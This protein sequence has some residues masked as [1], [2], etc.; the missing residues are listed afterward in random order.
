MSC[1]ENVLHIFYIA[2]MIIMMSVMMWYKS[3][4]V[5]KKAMH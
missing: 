5:N 1:L 2:V 4:K 3:Q